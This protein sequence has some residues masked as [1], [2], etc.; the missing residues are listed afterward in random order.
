MLTCESDKLSGYEIFR[1]ADISGKTALIISTW[2]G[3]GLFPEAP[4]TLGT[5]AAIPFIILLDFA[6]KWYSTFFLIFLAAVGIWAAGRSQDLLGRKDP[7]EVVVDEVAGIFLTMCLL[8]VSWL[9]LALGFA[10]F[11]IFDILKPYPIKRIEKF[12]GGFG[13][14]MDD[15]FAGL[16]AFVAVKIVLYFI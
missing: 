5:I 3:V 1:K 10:F 12:R 7:K 14:V 11:R 8:Q 2:F 13:I 9:T 16:Y 15:L 6:G 4:G